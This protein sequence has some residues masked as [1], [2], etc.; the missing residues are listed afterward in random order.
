[1]RNHLDDIAM[2]KSREHFGLLFKVGLYLGL[3]L[4]VLLRI[5]L[6]DFERHMGALLVALL[7]LPCVSG[8]E[9]SRG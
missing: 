8:E 9:N 4:L 5:R 2:I 7:L 1:M 3:G 6:Y